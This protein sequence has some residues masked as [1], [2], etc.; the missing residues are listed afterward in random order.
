MFPVDDKKQPLVKWKT[1][2]TQYATPAQVDDWARRWPKAGIGVATGTLSGVFVIDQDSAEGDTLA[3]VLPETATVQTSKGKHYYFKMPSGQTP[4]VKVR[5]APGLDLRGQGGYAVL[6]PSVHPDG[7]WYAWDIPPEEGIAECPPEVVKVLMRAHGEVETTASGG[8]RLGLEGV[9]EGSRNTTAA[10][11]I[12][13]LLSENDEELW[14]MLWDAIKYWNLGKNVVPLTEAE[15]LTTYRS[16]CSKEREKRNRT[17]PIGGTLKEL[18]DMAI[19]PRIWTVTGLLPEGCMLSV[20]KA[21]SGKTLFWQNVGLKVA[22]H[23]ASHL[24][25]RAP[26]LTFPVNRG[27]V[28]YLLLE[29]DLGLFKENLLKMSP[30]AE[31]PEDFEYYTKF[32]SLYEGGL[33]ALER[34]L[35]PDTRLVVIDTLAAFL[36]GKGKRGGKDVFG[37][38]YEM[39]APL[40]DLAHRRHIPIVVVTHQRK[41]RVLGGDYIDAI[42]GTLALPAAA[43]MFMVMDKPKPKST[44]AKLFVQGRG[45]PIELYDLE[46][47]TKRLEWEFTGVDESV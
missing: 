41:G 4:G 9:P 32:P 38:Q 27:H 46:L 37:D 21:K 43:D 10:S 33:A 13:K 18:R 26:G 19:P 1:F 30:L 6:P 40:R 25:S 42:S 11:L 7:H 2:Q 31:W 45:M 35:R 8:W 20:G 3:G 47:N 15:L 29:D 44:K 14:P 28:V 12:G 22:S 34:K 5:F 36:V 16:I 24:A 17:E 23:N 39:I